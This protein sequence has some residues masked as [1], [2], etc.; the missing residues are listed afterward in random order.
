MRMAIGAVI[1]QYPQEFPPDDFE[2]MVPDAKTARRLV[3]E[4]SPELLDLLARRRRRFAAL[5]DVA[6]APV[7][8]AEDVVLIAFC[9]L[10]YRHGSWGKDFHHYHNE[11]HIFEILGPRLER[12][13]DA[14]GVPALG[15][16]DWFLLALFAAAHD[17]RQREVPA[18]AAGIGSNERASVEE[19]FRILR[20]CGFTEERN[21][22]V[23]LAIELMISGSTF[24]ARPPPPMLEY[25]SAEIV[26]QSGG[27]LAQKLDEKLDKHA[28]GWRAD[29]RI[30]HALQLTL[31]AADLDT[32]N[33][34]EAF[35][36]FM[37]STER[38]CLEREMRS[39]R[40]PADPAA[41]LPVLNF[42]STGQGHYFFDLHRFSSD[43]GR[44]AF[45]AAKQANTEPMRK[46]IHELRARVP[47]P[48]NGT[49]VLETF[50][51]IVAE[52]AP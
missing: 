30:A 22:E 6:T 2:R 10:A 39:H 44:Q 42:L 49:Q 1:F 27:A 46:L 50:R 37:A 43:Y 45:A 11:G 52:L 35:P 8:P 48:R 3:S 14:V 20:M 41:A 19:T 36:I 33:V 16:R 17:L 5:I 40:D 26:V 15:L 47:A 7:Q 23:F 4:R 28:A 38:L 24:D 21:A 25:N 18:F 9:R 51:S 29:P 13:I 31:I 12:L 34:A 32:A